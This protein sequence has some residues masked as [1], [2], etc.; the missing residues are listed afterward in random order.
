MKIG[1]DTIKILISYYK[2]RNI[3]QPDKYSISVY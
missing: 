1:Q 3:L 2:E